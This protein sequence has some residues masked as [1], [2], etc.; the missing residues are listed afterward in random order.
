MNSLG[1]PFVI[2]DDAEKY[3]GSI[4]IYGRCE[5]ICA[6]D[7]KNDYCIIINF[8]PAGKQYGM[9]CKLTMMRMLGTLTLDLPAMREM[10]QNKFQE[11]IKLAK[12]EGKL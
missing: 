9:A 11:F 3:L 1:F 2:L 7:L 10:V 5:V 6:Y 12:A 8:Y 4:K